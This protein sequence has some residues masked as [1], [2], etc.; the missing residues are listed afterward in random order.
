MG[1][2]LTGESW[3]PV[4]WRWNNFGHIVAATPENDGEFAMGSMM[5][6]TGFS[7]YDATVTNYLQILGAVGGFFD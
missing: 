5:G 3:F 2:K 1:L 4:S 7:L 6:S